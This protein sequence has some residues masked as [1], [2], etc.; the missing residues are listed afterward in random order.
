MRKSMAAG[1]NIVT[2]RLCSA[3]GLLLALSF[4]FPDGGSVVFGETVPAELGFRERKSGTSI[5]IVTA[6]IR[7]PKTEDDE[8][9]VGWEHRKDICRRVLTAQNADIICCQEARIPQIEYLLEGMPGFVYFGMGNREPVIPSNP[10]LYSTVRFEKTGSGVFWLSKTPGVKGSKSWGS[11]AP[12]Y[13]NWISLREKKTGRSLVV[14]NTHFDYLSREA[15]ENGARV[16]LGM[17]SKLPVDAPQLFTGDFNAY[18]GS[19]AIDMIKQGGWTDTYAEMHGSKDP[20]LTAHQF[21]GA[22]F[23]AEPQGAARK[24]IDFVF[25]RGALKTVASEVV[26]DSIGGRYPSDHYF[27]SAEVEFSEGK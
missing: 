18:A 9:G 13:V 14:W 11:A 15:R 7:H 21:R 6:N 3:L 1:K 25:K 12:R 20:G 23:A 27:V 10:I 22:A 5:R 19:R 17:C 26:R 24:K 4:V 16:M 2:C 8:A